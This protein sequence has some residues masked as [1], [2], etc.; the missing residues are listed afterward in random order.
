MNLSKPTIGL[1]LFLLAVLGVASCNDGPGLPTADSV[2]LQSSHDLPGQASLSVS[3]TGDARAERV[4]EWSISCSAEPSMLTDPM[5][6]DAGF[7]VEVVEGPT[8]DILTL[9]GTITIH[10]GGSGVAPVESVIV[11]LQVKPGPGPFETGSS[12]ACGDPD[13]RCPY[14]DYLPNDASGELSI[15]GIDCEDDPLAMIDVG[16]TVDWDFEATFFLDALGLSEGDH[17]RCEVYVTFSNAGPRGGSGASCDDPNEPGG[18]LRGVASRVSMQVPSMT[19]VNGQVTMCTEICDPADPSVAT[20]SDFD[21]TVEN[22]ER[23][24]DCGPGPYVVP[25]DGSADVCCTIE[26][27]EMDGWVTKF[28]LSGTIGCAGDGAT[29]VTNCAE[30]TGDDPADPGRGITG[31]PTACEIAISCGQGGGGGGGGSGGDFCTQTQGGWG[32]VCHG[33]NPGCIRDAEFGNLFPNG[34]VIGDA[35]GD[36]ATFTSSAAVEAFLPAGGTPAPLGQ[37]YVNPMT[38]DAGIL[39]GQAV[40][41]TLNI[42]FD[43]LRQSGQGCGGGVGLAELLLVGGPCTGMTVQDVLDTANEILGGTYGGSLTPSEINSC[44]TTI[45]ENFVDCR[46]D[47]GDLRC[48]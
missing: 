31:S 26:A 6:S 13:Q 38:T 33:G 2:V 41:T 47:N 34:L 30:L 5:L 48:P 19:R 29:A 43:P 44:L 24:V 45:N 1:A 7:V 16:D 46:S 40:A 18:Y 21:L 11:N 42:A 36:T 4:T 20:V 22:G 32:T 37:D 35:A 28:I 27:T 15:D 8:H 10:N 39:A 25:A 17:I 23:T 9:D 14:T 3:K 12:V